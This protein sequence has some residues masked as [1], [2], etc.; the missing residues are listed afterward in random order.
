MIK[1]LSPEFPRISMIL[2][3]N[4]HSRVCEVLTNFRRKQMGLMSPSHGS[5]TVDDC[6]SIN[7][8][9]LSMGKTNHKQLLGSIG[10]DGSS[11]SSP[12]SMGIDHLCVKSSTS[13]L[14]DTYTSR[15]HSSPVNNSAN[16]R[17]ITNEDMYECD[18][19]IGRCNYHC[20][21]VL[22]ACVYIFFNSLRRPEHEDFLILPVCTCAGR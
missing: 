6:S 21:L 15:R 1:V 16:G 17:V 14:Q 5:Q 2:E 7:A 18:G 13:S 12:S 22:V 9:D 19:N 4:N 20:Q 3:I 10:E 8:L 11:P